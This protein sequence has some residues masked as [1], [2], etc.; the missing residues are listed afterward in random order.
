M[1][2]IKKLAN[3]VL[4]KELK[5]LQVKTRQL[6]ASVYEAAS[7]GR[8][9]SL[10]G[11]NSS[12]PNTI[13]SMD[14]DKMKYRA[15]KLVRD[16][17]LAG[18]GVASYVANVVGNGITPKWQTEHEEKNQE[19]LELWKQ[20]VP[21]MDADGVHDAYGLQSQVVRSVMVSGEILAHTII[22][23]SRLSPVPFQIRLLET[24]FLKDVSFEQLSRN[25]YIKLGIEFDNNNTKKAYHCYLEH[26]GEYDISPNKSGDTI[27]IPA[28][29]MLHVFVPLRP[30][31]IRG[32]TRFSTIITRLRQIDECEDAVL[33]KQKVAALFGAFIISR[34]GEADLTQPLMEEKEGTDAEGNEV[35]YGYL[36]PGMVHFLGKNAEDVKFSNPPDIGDNY[37][38]WIKQQLQELATGWEITYEQLTG[39]LSGVTFSSIRAGL[40]EFRRKCEQFQNNIIIHQ[41]CRPLAAKWLDTAVLSG[42]IKIPGYYKDR[43]KYINTLWIPDAWDY[44]NPEEDVDTRIKE[45]RAGFNSR[46]AVVESTTN[47]DVKEVDR[48]IE[49]DN[50]RADAKKFIL[51]SDARYVNRT[52]TKGAGGGETDAVTKPPNGRGKIK[53]DSKVQ[54]GQSNGKRIS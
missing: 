28:E 11:M 4:R 34:P 24:D 15:R 31:Q 40:N 13:L 37:H 51:D 41:Y 10:W 2:V 16:N 48:E 49:E 26:P 36:E 27:R 20:C 19:I 29:N 23:K 50:K 14:M 3:Y 12:G 35:T 6:E 18:G 44:V 8:R 46:T 54:N 5:Q 52:G 43:L 7:T 21:Y 30:G 42:A 39:D 32:V 45:V 1:N 17:P 33:T 9:M 25:R 53:V 22:N 47:R 38:N